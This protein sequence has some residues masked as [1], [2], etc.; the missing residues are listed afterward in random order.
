MNNPLLEEWNT[1]FGTPPFNIIEIAHYI[2]AIE[3]AIK[4]ATDEIN[5]ITDNTEVPDFENTIAALDRAGETLGKITSILFNLNSAETSKAAPGS[6]T[7]GI[8]A[9]YPLLK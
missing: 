2:P 6:S 8:P 4:M 9:P 3:E 5:S 7:G 1:P